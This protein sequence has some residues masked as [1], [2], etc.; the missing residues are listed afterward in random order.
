MNEQYVLPTPFPMEYF[1]TRE[2]KFLLNFISVEDGPEKRTETRH[3][4][5]E[6]KKAT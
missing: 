5:K 1:S 3:E 2:K 4:M 6:F